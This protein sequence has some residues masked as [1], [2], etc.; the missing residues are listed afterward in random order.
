MRGQRPFLLGQAAQKWFDSRSRD[1]QADKHREQA[2]P[3]DDQRTRGRSA[4]LARDL[5]RG[6]EVRRKTLQLDGQAIALRA[7]GQQ[8]HADFV[9]HIRVVAQGF[10][11]RAPLV[12]AG[13]HALARC[14]HTRMP[15]LDRQGIERLSH[16]QARLQLGREKARQTTQLL[17]LDS[18]VVR[19]LHGLTWK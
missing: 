16:R 15:E 18:L 1:R 3:Q 5:R 14:C 2:D 7:R 19:P 4:K 10:A 11:Q 13:L 17:W 8:C 12:H 6:T 9:K